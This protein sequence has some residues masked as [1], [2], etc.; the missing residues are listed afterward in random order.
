[1]SDLRNRLIRLAHARPDLRGDLLP[2]LSDKSAGVGAGIGY[3]TIKRERGPGY[4]PTPGD[5]GTQ[6]VFKSEAEA[7]AWARKNLTPADMYSVEYVQDVEP[8]LVNGYF[9]IKFKNYRVTPGDDG[10]QGV[11]KSEAEARAWGRKNLNPASQWTV[12]YKTN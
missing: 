11:F 12:V 1:M 8:D 9:S 4:R 6:G 2:L 3:Y 7:R 5:L 10:T